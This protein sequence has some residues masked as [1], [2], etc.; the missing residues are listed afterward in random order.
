MKINYVLLIIALLIS[1]LAAFG[2]YAANSGD[3]FRTLITIGSGLTLFITLSGAL[4]FSSPNGGTANIKIVSFIFFFV[5]IVEHLIFGFAGI[6]L[7]PYIIINGILI[8]LY[9]LIAYAI[10]RALK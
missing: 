8:L 9:I 2:F 6:R 1:G 4:A 10:T 5:F 3:T 7:T